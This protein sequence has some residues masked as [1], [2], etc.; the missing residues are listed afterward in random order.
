MS[1][2]SSQKSQNTP[3]LTSRFYPAYM[4]RMLF[5]YSQAE[6]INNA[7]EDFGLVRHVPSYNEY[8][9]F[10]KLIESFTNSKITS[11]KQYSKNPLYL[12]FFS[13]QSVESTLKS[14][15]EF[16]PEV[17]HENRLIAS[18]DVKKGCT[19]CVLS[20]YGSSKNEIFDVSL[21]NIEIRK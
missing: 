6:T 10:N 5:S 4:I 13:T 17:Q 8:N 19:D 11:T 3:M 9:E 14:S 18:F 21:K 2:I 20:L 7:L 15:I 16:S 12:Y 1:T